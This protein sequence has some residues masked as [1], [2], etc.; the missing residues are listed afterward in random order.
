[1][2]IDL[3]LGEE[4][5]RVEIPEGGLVLE[6]EPGIT[7]KIDPDRWVLL[8][9]YGKAEAMEL[10]EKG[11]HRE[12][13]ELFEKVLF[14][15]P[16]NEILKNLVRHLD[17]ALANP[18][19]LESDFFDVYLGKYESERG[20]ILEVYR[21]EGNL[22]LRFGAYMNFRL[23]PVSDNEFTITDAERVYTFRRDGDGNVTELAGRM[24]SYR[25]IE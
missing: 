12:A 7:P 25:K 17:Y 13:R 8:E 9:P 22:T 10:T 24:G 11:N 23:Y 4:I 6:L 2:P 19:R 20:T 1:M 15:D 18:D 5:R 14:V 16:G 3:K 21:D